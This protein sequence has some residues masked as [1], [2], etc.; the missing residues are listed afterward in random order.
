MVAETKRTPHKRI[1]NM[2]VTPVPDAHV[3]SHSTHS[4][5]SASPNT[6]IQA[7]KTAPEAPPPPAPVSPLQ[8][9]ILT[10]ANATAQGAPL[11][12]TRG[13]VMERASGG[14]SMSLPPWVGALPGHKSSTGRILSPDVLY[15]S[16][17]QNI[18][19]PTAPE[20]QTYG[21]DHVSSGTARLQKPFT[22]T[23]AEGRMSPTPEDHMIMQGVQDALLGRDLFLVSLDRLRLYNR[24]NSGKPISD[25]II[26]E[27]YDP[28]TGGLVWKNPR[29]SVEYAVAASLQGLALASAPVSIPA[30]MRP[31]VAPVPA[32]P[33][34]APTA[35]VYPVWFVAFRNEAMEFGIPEANIGAFITKKRASVLLQADVASTPE[36]AQA[37]A[38][39]QVSG[40]LGS[41]PA[42]APSPTPVAPVVTP[43]VIPPITPV[44]APVMAPRSSTED[45]A[46]ALGLTPV[47]S[48][49][50]PKAASVA[51]AVYIAEDLPE[52]L[53]LD[54]LVIKEWRPKVSERIVNFMAS[55][56]EKTATARQIREGIGLPTGYDQKG[57]TL[58]K[59]G[60][61][62]KRFI[63]RMEDDGLL[64]GGGTTLGRTYRLL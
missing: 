58:E 52:V 42:S 37:M 60:N 43:V 45:V 6:K 40:L 44:A 13:V 46:A 62:L 22:I 21:V 28:A 36:E 51:P 61:A 32:T 49:P 64:V 26:L 25:N 35:S 11:A 15:L 8:A 31:L 38:S 33:A 1:K 29:I 23:L 3:E 24:A 5:E 19:V 63:Y 55:C 59:I 34:P 27:A 18:P 54:H 12:V 53:G 9:A 7:S 56:P 16:L 57:G 2:D 10:V 14:Q 48:A 39:K 30:P 4:V 17:Y 41:V 47:A 20:F 50:T